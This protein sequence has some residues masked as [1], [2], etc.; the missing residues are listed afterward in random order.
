M[1]TL[2]SGALHYVLQKNVYYILVL[3]LDGAGKSSLLERFKAA[4]DKRYRGI[5]IDKISPTVGLGVG[6]VDIGRTTR[7]VFWDLGGQRDLHRLWPEYYTQAHGIVFVV[8]ASDRDRL[9]ESMQA[10]DNMGS[11]ETLAGVSDFY[12]FI[13]FF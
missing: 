3:G 5:S 13:L 4:H 7:L 8:D 1:Y 6:R 9:R 12:Y 10:F 2:L 11:N